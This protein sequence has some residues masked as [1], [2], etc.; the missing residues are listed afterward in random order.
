MSKSTTIAAALMLIAA[1][2]FGKA[3]DQLERSDYDWNESPALTDYVETDTNVAITYIKNFES[4]EFIDTDEGMREYVLVHKRVKVFTDQGIERF[5]KLYL[6][7]FEDKAFLKEKAR[8]IN[9]KGEVIVLKKD[10]I[11]EGVDEDTEQKFR[12]FALEGIDK[13]SEVEYIYMYERSPNFTGGLQDIQRKEFQIDYDYEMIVPDRLGL[14]FKVYND[15]KRFQK[16]STILDIKAKTRWYI[17]YDSLKGLP[18]ERSSAFEAELIYFGYK[19]SANYSTNA[20]DLFSYGELSKLIYKRFQEDVDKK[21][22]KFAKKIARKIDIEDNASDRQKIRAIEEYIKS[23]VRIINGNFPPD[24]EVD[25]LW[26]AK[27][28]S[29]DKAIILFG[30]LFDRYEINYQIGL[31]TDRFSFKFD[32]EFELWRY[33]D[34]YIFYFPSIDDYTTPNTYDRLDF[35][36]YNYIHNHGLFVKRV[37]LAG[38]KYGVGEVRFI[39]KNDY[40]DSGD[41]LRVEV[42]FNDQ[43]F[44]D[45]EYDVYHSV[46]GYKA[47]YIQPYFEEIDD[48]EDKTEL[49]ESLLTFLDEDGEVKSIEVK[50]LSIEEY[51]LNP[52]ISEGI[53]V[54]NKFFEK[55]R[56]NYLFKVG[57]LIGP[58]AEMYSTDNRTLPVEEYFARHY[59]RTIVFTIPEGYT[60]KNLENLNIHES[61]ENQEGEI[62]MEFKSVYSREGD[63]ITVRITEFYEDIVY[64]VSIF[65]AYQ[66]VINAAADFNKVVVIFDKD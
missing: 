51:G 48:Q 33:A 4:H 47:N 50:N 31:T 34:E 60:A 5:N 38:E 13:G 41:T 58:Q 15:D 63:K 39:P 40:K 42:D 37:E 25:E 3:N 49:K 43:G 18:E 21:D 52:V 30:E 2:S 22:E 14:S 44:I 19:L 29:Q 62:T 28:I 56:D 16:D 64:P 35:P 26:E 57:E 54:S 10:D 27:I 20:T 66:R 32:P 8:V 59:D 23:N 53:L 65:D 6:P 45:T 1:T 17:E 46:S 36:D 7:V 55:A 24:V 9:S 12:Y 11:K 61:Y